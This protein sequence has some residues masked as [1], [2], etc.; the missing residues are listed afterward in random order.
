MQPTA[1]GRDLDWETSISIQAFYNHWES[2]GASAQDVASSAEGSIWIVS[3]QPNESGYRVQKWDAGSSS[4]VNESAN[5]GAVR[6]ALG[7]DGIPWVVD[8]AGN[9]H[10]R[11]S[12]SPDD[13]SWIWA[14]NGCAQDIGVNGAPFGDQTVWIIGC[15]AGDAGLRVYQWNGN[16][17]TADEAGGSGVR[18]AVDSTGR[19]VVAN[20]AGEIWRKDSD[21]A[22]SGS[23]TQLSNMHGSDVAVG[24]HLG[25]EDPVDVVWSADGST[26]YV[27]NEQPGLTDGSDN[28]PQQR[29][30]GVAA[31]FTQARNIGDLTLS[32][33][34]VPCGI[35]SGQLY[36]SHP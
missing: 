5:G 27:F 10:R 15:D 31:Q 13:G 12:A 2:T 24:S 6:I 30:I 17:W 34:G 11:S 35:E 9:V 16:D 23:W 22:N 28:N 20:Q 1:A 7:S 32:A 33:A 3:D 21:S 25:T 18:I 8:S 4:F 19:P 36:C 14:E 29:A 26:L